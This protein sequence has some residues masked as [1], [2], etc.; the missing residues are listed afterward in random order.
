MVV[1]SFRGF[2][3]VIL[4]PVIIFFLFYFHVESEGTKK[5]DSG[6]QLYYLPKTRICRYRPFFPSVHICRWHMNIPKWK[7]TY[8]CVYITTLAA[9]SCTP[10]I[11]ITWIS[12]SNVLRGAY[13]QGLT[14]I[15]YIFVLTQKP[16]VGWEMSARA[17]RHQSHGTN[18]NKSK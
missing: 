3:D 9:A 11:N 2:S 8:N 10:S 6:C 1:L 13:I 4:L 5:K 17:G 12:I 15:L 18:V 7:E 16:V 14:C